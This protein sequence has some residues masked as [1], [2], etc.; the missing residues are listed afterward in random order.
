MVAEADVTETRNVIL[1]WNS[2]LER[3]NCLNGALNLNYLKLT[4][5]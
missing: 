1:V 5:N 3:Q 2:K 4:I